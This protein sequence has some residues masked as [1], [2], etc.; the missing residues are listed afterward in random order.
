MI[1]IIQYCS[2]LLFILCLCF[3][4][5][6]FWPW[7]QLSK[8]LDMASQIMLSIQNSLICFWEIHSY[9]IHLVYWEPFFFVCV[10][11][12]IYSIV[13]M[14]SFKSSDNLCRHLKYIMKSCNFSFNTLSL[15]CYNISSILYYFHWII[16]LALSFY[17][18]IFF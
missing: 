16:C 2:T 4:S 12:Y 9:Y 10:Y 15:S 11:I 7:N 1:K 14:I 8:T 17:F 5:L 18:F 13:C 6:P 3:P